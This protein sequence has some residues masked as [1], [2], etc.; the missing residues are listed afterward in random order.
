MPLPQLFE[1]D[2]KLDQH[3]DSQILYPLSI[4]RVQPEHGYIAPLRALGKTKK[5]N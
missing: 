5:V 3:K 2:K 4:A 1:E